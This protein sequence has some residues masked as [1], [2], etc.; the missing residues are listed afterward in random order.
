MNRLLDVQPINRPVPL[1][2]RVFRLSYLQSNQLY[3]LAECQFFYTCA[4]A[5]VPAVSAV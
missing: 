4:R 3:T 2:A 5:T 1:P